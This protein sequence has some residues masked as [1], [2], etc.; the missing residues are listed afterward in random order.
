MRIPTINRITIT[1]LVTMLLVMGNPN[2]LKR[3]SGAGE[4]A[5]FAN[6]KED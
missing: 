6:G 5:A 1:Q 2:T 4:T 3:L